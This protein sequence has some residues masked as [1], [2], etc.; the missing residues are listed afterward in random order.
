MQR[1]VLIR[2]LENYGCELLREGAEHSIYHNSTTG[3]RTT[4]PPH[5]E[6]EDLMARLICKQ[7]GVPE[8]SKWD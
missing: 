6:I 5:R 4:I 3:Q 7:L 2:H 8:P 1:R